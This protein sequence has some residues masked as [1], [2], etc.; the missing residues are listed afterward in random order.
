MRSDQVV[1]TLKLNIGLDNSSVSGTERTE[2]GKAE[3]FLQKK[4]I[5]I[6]SIQD[7]LRSLAQIVSKTH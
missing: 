5:M 1:L 4:C 7:A 3:C 2:A 6:F